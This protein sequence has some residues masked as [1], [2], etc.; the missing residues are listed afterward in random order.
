MWILNCL[1]KELFKPWMIIF[2]SPDNLIIMK[3]SLYRDAKVKLGCI[4]NSMMI[5]IVSTEGSHIFVTILTFF[6]NQNLNFE[7]KIFFSL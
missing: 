4:K 1:R 7:T 6:T 2:T 5:K 3:R